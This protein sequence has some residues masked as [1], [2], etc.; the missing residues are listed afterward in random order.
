MTW[1][2]IDKISAMHRLPVGYR[3]EQLG[4]SEIPDLIRAIQTW[5]PDISV[6]IGSCYVRENFY[7]DKVFLRG[8]KENDFY[9]VLI[10]Y[11]DELAGMGSWE[12]EPDALTLYT[13][14]GIVAPAH[15]GTGVAG[16]AVEFTTNLA[17][18]MGAGFVYGLATLKMP[19]AQL[20]LERAGYQLLGFVPGYDRELV[21]PGVVKRVY[22][23]VYAKVLVSEDELLRPDPNNLSPKAR[24]L[25]DLLFPSPPTA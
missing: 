17:R 20:A 8:E 13:R 1:P 9:V 14:L 25:W 18:A 15:R 22:E 3:Y 5:H 12:W 6:G 19:Q 4:R 7:H 10:K 11:H 24:A 2:A 21:A 23:A 16:R